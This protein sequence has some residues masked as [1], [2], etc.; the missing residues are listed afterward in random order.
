VNYYAINPS[1]LLLSGVQA[2][3]AASLTEDLKW[4]M[5]KFKAV[6]DYQGSSK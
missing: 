2:E 4:G 5:I 3:T 1:F 6:K